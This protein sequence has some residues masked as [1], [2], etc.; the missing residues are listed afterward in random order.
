M[1]SS[2]LHWR[3]YPKLAFEKYSRPPLHQF[4]PV[5]HVGRSVVCSSNLVPLPVCELPLDHIRVPSVFVGHGREQGPE[6]L[7]RGDALLAHARER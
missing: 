4:R 7:R 6:S 2:G 3:Q 1:Q 5:C